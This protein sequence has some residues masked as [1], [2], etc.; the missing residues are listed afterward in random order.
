MV[1]NFFLGLTRLVE[2]ITVQRV[3]LV[4]G[5]TKWSSF[6]IVHSLKTP[7]AAKQTISFISNMITD[8]SIEVS[9]VTRMLT[10]IFKL[11]EIYI[12]N[13]VGGRASANTENTF[14]TKTYH[15]QGHCLKGIEAV[16]TKAGILI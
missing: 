7:I 15:Q 13:I 8:I 4:M 11:L 9:V 1:V 10:Y 6:G 16:K 12:H 14:L 2:A 3:H 5:F